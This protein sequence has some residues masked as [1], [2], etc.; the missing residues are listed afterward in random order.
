[1]AVP[2]PSMHVRNSSQS[3][4]GVQVATAS[5]VH[6]VMGDVFSWPCRQ[7]LQVESGIIEGLPQVALHGV[8]HG[9]PGLQPQAVSS[10]FSNSA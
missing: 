5:A 8:M 9:L 10:Y 1:M 6:I 7:A 3:P 4:W 2:Q